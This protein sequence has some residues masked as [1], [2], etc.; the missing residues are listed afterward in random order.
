MALEVRDVRVVL[1]G[2]EI[3]GKIR[4]QLRKGELVAL[5]GPNGSGKSTLMKSIYGIL[6]PT[7]GVVYIDGRELPSLERRDIAKHL[8]YLPQESESAGLSVLDVVLFGRLPYSHFSPGR[9]DYER[10]VRALKLV[11][12]EEYARRNFSELSGGEK[13]KVLLARIFCQE[14]EY[15]LLDE[16]TSHLDIKSQ[17]EIM[18][19]VRKLV[20][21]GKGALVAMH[22]VNLAAMFSDRV[23]M[24][25]DGKVVVDGKTQEVLTPE[26]IEAVYGIGVEVVRHNGSIVVVPK[27]K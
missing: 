5:L 3:I 4:L 18:E 19:I 24:L 20:D 6:R 2:A 23:V 11:G 17:V 26:N 10:A 25:K 9:D 27:L 12:M 15:L 8:G 22:D 1:G 13:Q 16:P 7:G 14:T 21:S